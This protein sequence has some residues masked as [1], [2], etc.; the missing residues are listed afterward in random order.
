MHTDRNALFE[1]LWQD[2][3]A[4]T[5]SAA[6]IHRILGAEEG[7]AIINDHIA[8]RTFNLKPVGLDTL[9][10]HFLAL[11]YREGGEYHFE[12]K[13]LYARHYEH[14]DPEAPKVFISELLTE[15]CSPELQ[16][17]ASQLVDGITDDK[18]TA[19]NFLYS[20]RHW[21]LDSSTYRQLLEESEYAAWLGAWGYRANHFTVS[22]NHLTNF[23]TVT[24]INQLL[25]DKGFAVNAA[26]GEVKGSPEELLEQSSTMA[27]R[28]PVQFSD[29]EMTIPSC[30]YEFALRYKKPNGTLYSGFVAASADK[31]FESTNAGI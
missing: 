19:D 14:A 15:Q 27:D 29:R 5:P 16:A 21:D 4:V 11:G 9:A 12:G 17:I 23:E 30:F 25:K 18:V 7:Q 31:I 6:K 1:N 20:G 10:A 8:L 3:R 13:K 24:D 22:V 28:V 26:G 2:Y